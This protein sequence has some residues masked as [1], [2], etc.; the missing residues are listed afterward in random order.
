MTRS[1]LLVWQWPVRLLHW[2]LVGA[3]VGSWLTR[4]K[5]GEVH[6][7]WGYAAA[8]VVG[9]RLFWS[10]RGNRYARFG[11]FVRAAGPTRDYARAVLAGHAPR[12][13]G[14]N[15]LGGWMVVALLSCLA[16]LTL[17]GSLYTTDWLWGYGWL[18]DLHAGLGW[19]LLGLVALHIGGVL[20]TSWQHRENL[21]LAML[22]G[23]KDA[24]RDG[25]ID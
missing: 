7:Y 13:L 8:A 4:S 5:I 10:L 20:F 14:H 2:L 12:Y 22:T 23:R 6:Q 24:P 18:A 17:T 1:R 16:M 11:R 25:D 15:P 19:L 3:V 21:V 9:L